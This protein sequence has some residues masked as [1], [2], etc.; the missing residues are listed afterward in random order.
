MI[1]RSCRIDDLTSYIKECKSDRHGKK[2]KIEMTKSLDFLLSIDDEFLFESIKNGFD[3]VA[4]SQNV[5][6][7]N[8]ICKEILLFNTAYFPEQ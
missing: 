1:F 6:R 3:M 5:K 8:E 7:F 4:K 2:N